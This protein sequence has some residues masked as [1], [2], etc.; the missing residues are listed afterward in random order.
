[1]IK[2][3]LFQVDTPIGITVTTTQDYW[4]LIE[5]KHPEI[6]GKLLL[7]KHALRM[8]DTI[9]QS[10]T[11]KQVLLFYRKINGYWIC[12]VAKCNTKDGFVIT[13]YL[14]DKIKEGVKIWP[15]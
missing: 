5:K 4:N 6:N 14:T 1:M 13:S 2:G 11:D 10:K 3:Y 7:A 9:R 12:V 15:N 8:P